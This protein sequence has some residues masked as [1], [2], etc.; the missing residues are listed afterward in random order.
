MGHSGRDSS[1]A[2]GWRLGPALVFFGAVCFVTSWLLPTVGDY[3]D[4]QPGLFAFV[5]A[6]WGAVVG[7]AAGQ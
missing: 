1:T 7:L 3:D 4:W 5:A 2:P 6:P